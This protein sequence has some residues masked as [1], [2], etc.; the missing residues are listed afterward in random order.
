MLN[1]LDEIVAPHP[2]HIL[3]TFIPL[4]PVY[5]E[6]EDTQNFKNLIID[7][8]RLVKANPVPWQGIDLTEGKVFKL[9]SNH[10]IFEIFR[11]I[12]EIKADTFGADFWCCKS[13]QNVYLAE[14]LEYMDPFYIHLIRDG[15]DV[16][17]SFKKAI[18][19]EKHPYF[20]GL[21]WKND[22]FHSN[23]L[24]ESKGKKR[25]IRISYENLIR[26]PEKIIRSVCN[27]I[28]I[29]YNPRVMDFYHSR[30]S[31][32][33]AGAGEM[34]SNLKKPIIKNN[35][36]KYKKELRPDE[37]EIFEKVAGTSLQEFGYTVNRNNTASVDFSP[38]QLKNFQDENKIL[39]NQ[40]RESHTYDLLK[41]SE[42]EELIKEI[43]SQ[44]S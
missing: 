6:L 44:I 29:D 26:D 12:Y 22:Q 16:A 36:N 20:L 7:V 13:M 5:G 18:V 35:S 28:G 17:A 24:V 42:Q 27:L 33:T 4:L 38:E 37:I 34:W 9:C 15:R 39:K 8:I 23:Q 1:Q 32:I 40:S 3:K 19:G 2:P 10:S 41:R 14:Q 11:A 25:A 43:A 30:E 31:N 21:Q